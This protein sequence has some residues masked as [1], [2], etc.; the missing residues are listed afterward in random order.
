MRLVGACAIQTGF[1]ARTRLD[2]AEHGNV[3]AL[4]LRDVAPNGDIDFK[5]LTR[6][7]LDPIP[8]KYLVRSG[9]VVFR[10]R[11]ESTTAAVIDLPIPLQVLAVLPLMILRPNPQVL[12]GAWLAWTINQKPAQRHFEEN[13]QGTSLRMISR[14]S[15][16]T[17]AIAIPSLEMQQRI[18]RMDALA[19]R[20]RDLARQLAH[21]RHELIRRLL[22][23]HAG[24]HTPVPTTKRTTK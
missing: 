24:K 17:L 6:I 7:Y 16:E 10:S 1:T 21:V 8:E 23:E 2:P 12:S 22:I 4:Q 13:A 18:L 3:S 11:G 15:L 5:N 9:D 14:S 20:E 19:G